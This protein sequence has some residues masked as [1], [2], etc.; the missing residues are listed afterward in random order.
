MT[1]RLPHDDRLDAL[2]RW[3]VLLDSYF[4]VPG[5]RIR[6]GLDALIGLESSR[7]IEDA[8]PKESGLDRPRATVRLKTKDGEKGRN[9][10]E[11]YLFPWEDDPRPGIRGDVMTTDEADEFLGWKLHAV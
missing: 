2:R 7:T 1:T 3:A 11:P 9:Y 5:T 4:R 8:D 10:P 6:F